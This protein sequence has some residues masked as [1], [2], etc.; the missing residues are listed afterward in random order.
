MKQ[1]ITSIAAMNAA[2]YE[3]GLAEQEIYG[4]SVVRADG[5]YELRFTTDFVA[6][7]CYVDAAD[8]TVL[9]IDTRPLAPE[10]VGVRLG[11]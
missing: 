2:F 7:D 1:Y 6:Y 9:G 3:L 5:L 4:L 8:G 10:T 11:A